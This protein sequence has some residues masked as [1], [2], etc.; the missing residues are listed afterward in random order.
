MTDTKDQEEII[1]N[2]DTADQTDPQIDNNETNTASNG[3]ENEHLNIN[4]EASDAPEEKT[5]AEKLTEAEAQIASLKDQLLRQ[6]AE[7]D[8]YRKRTIKE[9]SELIL[10]GGQK[11]LES[12]LPVLDDLERAQTNMDKSDDV[13]TLKEGVELI[14]DKLTKTLSTQGLSKIETDGSAFDTD[15]HE[16]IALVPVE[17]KSKKTRL[18]TVFK[19]DTRSTA[20]LSV[21]RKL[22]SD[23]N[24][25]AGNACFLKWLREGANFSQNN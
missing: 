25:E 13:A 24:Q 9:K 5:D 18:S 11:V 7:F 4:E 2:N 21:M 14:I 20:R 22:Q 19:L 15:F 17:D 12:L 16:A 23:N 3:E 1:K 6:M 10:N 8:N